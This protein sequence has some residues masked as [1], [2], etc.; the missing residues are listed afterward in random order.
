MG[1]VAF[2]L[3]GGGHLGAAEVGMLQALIER[4]IRPDVVVGTSVGAL[5]GAA[6]ASDPS[7]DM[8][9]RL[10][11]LWEDID[12]NE[13]FGGSL[14]SGAA[15]LVRTRTHLHTNQALRRLLS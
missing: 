2:V 3:G 4:G 11:T 10:R 9:K 15:N 6:V 12:R 1:R 14:L 13:V 7:P 5:N 8:V